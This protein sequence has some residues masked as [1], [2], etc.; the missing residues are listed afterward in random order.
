[1]E[2]RKFVGS[3]ILT[4]LDALV[5]ILCVDRG[6]APVTVVGACYV[7]LRLF[8][9]DA[10]EAVNLIGPFGDTVIEAGKGLVDK[11]KDSKKDPE[12][13]EMHDNV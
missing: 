13:I 7:A 9:A 11:V 2:N 10:H 4:V 12:L 3:V 5:F 6:L 8:S 1:M